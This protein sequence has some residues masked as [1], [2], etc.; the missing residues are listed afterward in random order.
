[1][2]TNEPSFDV[3]QYRLKSARR[4]KRLQKKDFEKQIIQIIRKQDALWLQKQQLPM[5]PL[6][7]P[8]QKGW[9]RLF[10]L[11]DE[12]K[13]SDRAIF[14]QALLDKINTVWYSS[15]RAFK[16]KKRRNRARKRNWKT[17]LMPDKKQLLHEFSY[18]EWQRKELTAEEREHFHSYECADKDGRQIRVRYR[19]NES[20]RFVLQVRPHIITHK[21]MIDEQLEQE[22]Q[23][24]DNQI[25]NHYLRPVMNKL[26]GRRNRYRWY[27]WEK[28]AD[29][30]PMRNLTLSGFLEKCE[31]Q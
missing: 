28:P 2:D 8:Y 6:E 10:V 15:D 18:S 27:S 3:L 1:M 12:L 19:F 30:N 21:K 25:K 20:W 5:V 22:I 7:S 26:T 9:K 24:L 4:K 23:L 16:V 14:Y 29:R 13:R 31:H 17:K 11:N